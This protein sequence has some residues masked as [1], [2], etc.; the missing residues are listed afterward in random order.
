MS[1]VFTGRLCGWLCADCQ[2]PL[3]G[4]SIRLYPVSTEGNV[5]ARAVAD[6]KDTVRI[7]DD[8][9][10]A[11][12]PPLLGEATVD[13]QG[14]FRVE[15]ARGY[16]GGAFDV[17]LYCGNVPRHIPP[18]PRKPVQ[19]ALT[20]L[21]PMWRGAEDD[22]VAAWSYCLP[23]RVWCG[24]RSL[25]GAWVICGRL[26]TC[27]GS[28]P[29]PGATV[30]A[31]DA[32]WWQDDD[33][34]SGVTDLTGHFRID[35]TTEDFEKTPFSP[36][37]NVEW[38]PGPDVYFK[39]ELGGNVILNEPRSAG[40]D[41]GRENIGNCFC[42][43][44]CSDDVE[45][46][47]QELVPHWEQVKSG[48]ISFDVHPAAPN[49]AS[50]FSSDGYA[51][52]ASM[53][54][55]G[56]PVILGGNCPLRDIATSNPLQY[57]F[58]IGEYTQLGGADGPGVIPSVA[59]A[60]L[61]PVVAVGNATVGYVYYPDAFGTPSSAPVVVGQADILPDGWVQVDG[62]PV[63]VDMHD[64][65]TAVVN[66]TGT[67]FL[68]TFDLLVMDTVA[69]TSTHP[70]K[71]PGGVPD[72]DAG[73]SLAPA[74]QEPIRRYQMAF[75]VR[76]AGTSGIVFSDGLSAIILDNTPVIEAL[77]LEELI[78]SS[79]N[80]VSG[81][82]VHLLYTVDHPHLLSFNIQI[83]NNGGV[84]HPAPP[85]PNGAFAGNPFFRGGASGPHQAAFNGGVSVGVGGDPPCAYLVRLSWDTR[86]L[87][88]GILAGSFVDKLY[89]K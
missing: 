19:V 65:T 68:R 61:A 39:A 25:F 45:P 50:D 33:L 88:N 20:T 12:R 46:G 14:N 49:P 83:S 80:P 77:N 11:N 31:F 82:A 69:L 52:G 32:D 78:V 1:Y 26:V 72:P 42:V 37:I 17:D 15:L 22:F 70:A 67:N 34:G 8:E 27:E 56:G 60:S 28:A 3:S 73:R 79:C 5:V 4:I 71:L 21:Q 57:R 81:A 55:L 64:G 76:D 23:V 53:F 7:L 24:I 85:L 29:I 59:P 74:E 75:Q 47:S 10:A 9:R 62:K 54:V 40:R 30:R 35:Y 6:P 84:V 18:K 51:G 36:T 43:E 2:E 38:T 13:E 63:T 89:C 16:D 44:L 86:R 58:L 87:V 41:P 66:V 48:A